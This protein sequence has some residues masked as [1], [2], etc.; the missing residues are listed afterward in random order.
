MINCAIY[1]R[2]SKANDNSESMKMQVDQCMEYLKRK[3]GDDFHAEIYNAD[4]GV[5]G[6]SI[7]KRKDFQRMMADV[8]SGKIKCVIAYKYDRL[9]RNMYDFV[10]FCH[11]LEEF[12]CILIS[13][14]QD[15][16]AS[17]PA[18]KQ[19]MYTFASFAEYEWT[20][21]STRRKDTNAYLAKIGKNFHPK[22]RLPLG[23]KPGIVDG[24]KKVVK[25]EAEIEMVET[26]IDDYLKYETFNHAI[27]TLNQKFGTSYDVEVAKKILKGDFHRGK[28]RDNLNYCEPYI[29]SE[30][31]KKIDE[32]SKKYVRHFAQDEFCYLFSTLIVCPICKRKLS[33]KRASANQKTRTVFY[34]CQCHE[35]LHLCEFGKCVN[36]KRT[37]EY[38]LK[39]ID[40]CLNQYK[41][42]V[43]SKQPK[44]KKSDVKLLKEQMERLTNSYIKGRIDEERY[45]FEYEKLQRTINEIEEKNNKIGRKEPINLPDQWEKTYVLLN[46]TNKRAFWRGIIKEIHVDENGIVNDIIF[47]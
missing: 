33:G 9:S 44:T 6:Y 16:D 20:I 45:D 7:K 29:D 25:D 3:Y 26:V 40:D 31:A 8:K 27:R 21:N 12:N 43:S 30:T 22:H 1:P 18:S 28:Y 14:T 17:N 34:K 35:R 47:L 23:Y 19:M 15:L 10:N 39:N 46:R 5:T 37:E 4:Y 36:E 24:M 41:V 32:I 2:K 38:I 11:E 42:T 13:V